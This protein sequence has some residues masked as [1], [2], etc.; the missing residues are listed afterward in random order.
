MKISK[1]WIQAIAGWLLLAAVFYCYVV[2]QWYLIGHTGILIAVLGIG[3]LV[4]FVLSSLEMALATLSADA[5][6]QLGNESKQLDDAHDNG[7]IDAKAHSAG[8][9]RIFDLLNIYYTREDLNPPLT[10]CSNISSVV[11]TAF[12]PLAI[13]ASITPSPVAIDYASI[14]SI[15]GC[16]QN[17]TVSLP[18]AGKETLIF[19]AV[20]LLVIIF[21]EIVPKKL[22][23]KYNLWFVKQF[24]VPLRVLDFLFGWLGSALL[25]PLSKL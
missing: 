25:L 18:G 9:S 2:R 4:S 19:F 14:G 20:V 11:M 16:H 23:L 12:A 15:L 24:R 22:G 21:G 7:R 3:V 1:V 10:I 8:K 6:V 17:C 5:L 13:T